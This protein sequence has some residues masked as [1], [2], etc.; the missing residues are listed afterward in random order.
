M[1]AGA[2][3]A[4]APT[5]HSSPTVLLTDRAWPDDMV[6]R[7]VLETAGVA[8]VSGPRDAAPAAVIER[9]V[10][11]QEPAAIMT[12]W[13]QVSDAAIAASPRLRLVARMGVGLDNIAVDA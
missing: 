11:E 9:L 5:P 10:A 4:T 1:P 3:P 12:C 7:D 6:E 8:L 2:H 13:A